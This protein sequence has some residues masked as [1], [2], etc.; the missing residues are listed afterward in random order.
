MMSKDRTHQLVSHDESAVSF[1]T[2]LERDVR[3][4]PKDFRLS[5]DWHGCVMKAFLLLSPGASR[6][7][8]ILRRILRWSTDD[9]H[10]TTDVE[11]VECSADLLEVKGAK[12]SSK[13][14]PWITGRDALDLLTTAET[15]TSHR[16]A[17]TGL[18]LR[19]DRSDQQSTTRELAKDVQEPS[20]SLVWG[21]GDWNGGAV[22]CESTSA[23]YCA[24]EKSH[25]WDELCES[26]RSAGEP[27]GRCDPRSSR[28]CSR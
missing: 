6:E 28:R 26:T 19:S 21:S 14:S 7:R 20:A 17:G 22:T 8:A 10:E 1:R 24:T 2:W 3:V 13:S 5:D 27:H 4:K 12:M 25:D 23:K 15:A 11:R 16:A 9:V 18:Y